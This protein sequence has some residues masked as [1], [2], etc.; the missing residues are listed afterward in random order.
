VWKQS[1]Q[2]TQPRSQP[3][4]LPED[5]LAASLSLPTACTVPIGFFTSFFFDSLSID[6]SSA[7]IDLDSR[8]RRMAVSAPKTI[9]TNDSQRNS[10]V[11]FYRKHIFYPYYRGNPG[12]LG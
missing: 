11:S 4:W 7:E 12:K 6:Y 2:T 1:S 3:E 9:K 8:Q 10:S 5:E